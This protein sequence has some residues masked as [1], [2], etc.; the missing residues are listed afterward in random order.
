MH[1]TS[2]ASPVW[3]SYAGLTGTALLCIGCIPRSE[4]IPSLDDVYTSCVHELLHEAA[5]RMESAGSTTHF[6]TLAW[7]EFIIQMLQAPPPGTPTPQAGC[8]FAHA[9]QLQAAGLRAQ[10]AAATEARVLAL[11][12]AGCARSLRPHEYA[13]SLASSSAGQAGTAGLAT[14]WH[15]AS[16]QHKHAFSGVVQPLVPHLAN[17]LHGQHGE[18]AQLCAAAFVSS[19]CVQMPALYPPA[20]A[21]LTSL[22][23]SAST[24][25]MGSASA[26]TWHSSSAAT[27]LRS[28]LL[29]AHCALVVAQATTQASPRPTLS[30]AQ[31]D[32]VKEM[33]RTAR[34]ALWALALGRSSRDS[35]STAGTLRASSRA[36]STGAVIKQAQTTLAWDAMSASDPLWQIADRPLMSCAWTRAFLGMDGSAS[37]ASQLPTAAMIS[38][39]LASAL[40]CSCEA[41]GSATSA[42]VE[43]CRTHLASALHQAKLALRGKGAARNLGQAVSLPGPGKSARSSLGSAAASAPGALSTASWHVILLTPAL[44]SVLQ[45][46]PHAARQLVGTLLQF[47]SDVADDLK[48]V[49]HGSASQTEHFARL[50]FAVVFW[51]S[52]ARLLPSLP[53]EHGVSIIAAMCAA[54]K[55][56]NAKDWAHSSPA[57]AAAALALQTAARALACEPTAARLCQHLRVKLQQALEHQV[58]QGVLKLK[59]LPS[60]SA[61]ERSEQQ[62][63]QQLSKPY[64]ADHQAMQIFSALA[65]VATRASVPPQLVACVPLL[66]ALGD[67]C[68]DASGAA[69]TAG[70]P[71]PASSQYQMELPSDGTTR[72]AKKL[73]LLLVALQWANARTWAPLVN[74]PQRD[75][76]YCRLFRPGNMKSMRESLTR[77]AQHT[78]AL[79]HGHALAALADAQTLTAPLL[80]CGTAWLKLV[81]TSGNGERGWGWTGRADDAAGYEALLQQVLGPWVEAW[82]RPTGLAVQKLPAAVLLSASAVL[83]LE[84]AR[85]RSSGTCSIAKAQVAYATDHSV[86]ASEQAEQRA[87]PRP[88]AEA[89]TSQPAQALRELARAA[90]VNMWQFHVARQASGQAEPNEAARECMLQHVVHAQPGVAARASDMLMRWLTCNLAAAAD[91]RGMHS[92]R[93]HLDQCHALALRSPTLALPEGSA[94]L[95][96]FAPRERSQLLQVLGAGVELLTSWCL[97]AHMLV[98]P[99]AVWRAGQQPAAHAQS[100]AGTAALMAAATAVGAPAPALPVAPLGL[101]PSTALLSDAQRPALLPGH[102]LQGTVWGSQLECSAVSLASAGSVVGYL[103]SRAPFMPAA[104]AVHTA[105]F[106]LLQARKRSDQH[107]AEALA[108]LLPFSVLALKRGT[109]QVQLPAVT[110]ESDA[111]RVAVFLQPLLAGLPF[112]SSA[113]TWA[114]ERPHLVDSCEVAHQITGAAS[115]RSGHGTLLSAAASAPAADWTMCLAGA[116]SALISCNSRLVEGFMRQTRLAARLI[117]SYIPAQ[118]AASTGWAALNAVQQALGQIGMDRLHQPGARV[119]LMHSLAAACRMA[120]QPVPEP[121]A[122]PTVLAVVWALAALG[123]GATQHDAPTVTALW[124]WVRVSDLGIGQALASAVAAQCAQASSDFAAAWALETVASIAW[125]DRRL[126]HVIAGQVLGVAAP[127]SALALQA[128]AWLL[129]AVSSVPTVRQAVPLLNT[130]A[131]RWLSDSQAGQ[132]LG[133]ARSPLAQQP[134]VSQDC[135]LAQRERVAAL[136]VRAC[137]TVARPWHAMHGQDPSAREL[138]W[139]AQHKLAAALL[140]LPG[141]IQLL[142]DDAMP[143]S[144]SSRAPVFSEPSGLAVDSVDQRASAAASAAD[145]PAPAVVVTSAGPFK[146]A[147]AVH[148]DPAMAMDAGAIVRNDGLVHLVSAL[149]VCVSH[150]AELLAAWHNPLGMPERRLPGMDLA[151]SVHKYRVGLASASVAAMCE[152]ASASA[153]RPASTTAVRARSELLDPE[154][155]YAVDVPWFARQGSRPTRASGASASAGISSSSARMQPVVTPDSAAQAMATSVGWGI[156]PI[157]G[158]AVSWGISARS[159]EQHVQQLWHVGPALAHAFCK[160]FD[161]VPAVQHQAQQLAAANIAQLCTTPAWVPLLAAPAAVADNCPSLQALLYAPRAALHETVGL[162]ARCSG[163]GDLPKPIAAHPAISSFTARTLPQFPATDVVFWLP[164]LVQALRHDCMHHVRQLLTV[165]AA[166]SNLVAHQLLWALQ[167]ESKGAQAG[168]AYGFQGQL[169]GVDPLPAVCSLMKDRVLEALT[170]SSRK[171]YEA[172]SSFWEQVTD[173]SGRLKREVPRQGDKNGKIQAFLSEL[174]REA[175]ADAMQYINEVAKGTRAAELRSSSGA[176]SPAQSMPL[177]TRSP[178]IAAG[179]AALGVDVKELVQSEFAARGA[180]P[181][182]ASEHRQAASALLKRGVLDSV[183]YLPTNPYLRLRGVVM[184]SGRAMQSAAKCPFLLRFNVQQFGGPDA[185]PG[186]QSDA[187]DGRRASGR[188]GEEVLVVVDRSQRGAVLLGER[189]SDRSGSPDSSLFEDLVSPEPK[190][191]SQQA[192]MLRRLIRLQRKT[193]RTGTAL[194]IKRAKLLSKVQTGQ[195]IVRRVVGASSRSAK[196]AVQGSFAKLSNRLSHGHKTR[197]VRQAHIVGSAMDTSGQLHSLQEHQAEDGASDSVRSDLS[198]ASMSSFSI[199]ATSSSGSSGAGEAASGSGQDDGAGGAAAGGAAAPAKTPRG[200][201]RLRVRRLRLRKRSTEAHSTDS[202]AGEHSGAPAADSAACIFKVYDDTRQDALALQGLKLMAKS[203]EEQRVAVLTHAYNVVPMRIGSERAAGGV[204]EVVPDARSMDD[205]G[206]SGSASLWEYFCQRFGG[207]HAPRFQE[208]TEKFQASQAAYAIFCLL[209]WVKDRHNGNILITGDGQLVHIDFGFL[210]G[211]SP[212][213]NLGFETAP[214]KFTKEMIDLLG[215]M[216]SEGML[217]FTALVCRSLLAMSTTDGGRALEVAINGMADSGLEAFHFSWTL[218]AVRQRLRWGD[219]PTAIASFMADRVQDAAAARATVMY[220]GIQ[221]MQNNIHSEAWQ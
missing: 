130:K 162:W 179:A 11:L 212:G 3:L 171:L 78:S 205:I 185:G 174:A 55:S 90:V 70:A 172:Q 126:V 157:S 189:A 114:W 166:N 177:A 151:L 71:A 207:V 63:A 145:M 119:E 99:Q 188:G 27:H 169:S 159:W 51:G 33:L 86:F 173:I 31:G 183:L 216:R 21:T 57:A 68:A 110:A 152:L 170:P 148:M 94:K 24:S 10:Q 203:W 29:A 26:G 16:S 133:A 76:V 192:K 100:L 20:C 45:V 65:S 154:E 92:L 139:A 132:L 77:I 42:S 202:E 34:L 123:C 194:G 5:A 167:T 143:M 109:W 155:V 58:A 127:G 82:C 36:M 106:A 115:V 199:S 213:G 8:L 61:P 83:L 22:M 131:R 18:L 136:L 53:Y 187:Q 69:A 79:F 138:Q 101:H 12:C 39:A 153:A 35:I 96:P 14:S 190:D 186:T 44:V 201:R 46:Q 122:S 9:L 117:S 89:D 210:L 215:G 121:L 211:I 60:S 125:A 107:I 72:A 66:H 112:L 50:S 88:D 197:E 64:Q 104:P 116:Q 102:P 74:L 221:K 142:A 23:L 180:G 84:H 54:W 75:S 214:F 43:E 193:T 105:L 62:L 204:L 91:W 176:V 128:T 175:K 95:A 198:V 80:R 163:A 40:A 97:R 120:A 160:R 81:R 38:S 85:A 165:L 103:A 13:V 1:Q 191:S 17:A 158:S 195:L 181:G 220:D 41:G 15:E 156:G 87:L 4:A 118:Q 32:A 147:L 67:A 28:T 141:R 37:A 98:G 178:G 217:E 146:R 209:M 48:G 93:C 113:H 206:K 137:N 196:S 184:D 182:P 108:Q 59:T 19:A 134:A 219:A 149:I 6:A 150:D 200:R 140:A 135:V 111:V 2:A 52:A 49:P 7:N 168:S 129:G 25:S 208:A 47:W 56:G 161:A 124:D 164:Q 73:W 144:P 30:S 218:Q